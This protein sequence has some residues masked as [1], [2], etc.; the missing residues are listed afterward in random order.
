MY[1]RRHLVPQLFLIASVLLTAQISIQAQPNHTIVP[2]TDPQSAAKRADSILADRAI[3]ALEQLNANV[4]VYR[5]YGEFENDG[6]I[7][8]VTLET[9]TDRLNRVTFEIELIVPQLSDAKLRS[10]LSN[11]L[12]SYRDGA[13][14][15]AKLDQRKI[16]TIS[17]LR[18]GFITTTPTECYL[19]STVPYTVVIHWRQANK[20]LL[21]AQRLI[22][23]GEH[24]RIQ[25]TVVH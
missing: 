20:Y 4:F 21:R 15:W 6:R 9:F 12:Y 18:I 7:A 2:S 22:V 13:F 14:W 11:S 16:V 25:N 24:L 1:T 17:S 8:P 10:Y 23:E 3:A 5:S 19:T